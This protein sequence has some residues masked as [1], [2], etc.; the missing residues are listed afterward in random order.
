MELVLELLDLTLLVRV[1]E[2]VDVLEGALVGLPVCVLTMLLD[3][4]GDPDTVLELVEV[5]ETVELGEAVL[6]LF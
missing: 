2:L 5:A 3:S 1:G 4:T 6:E